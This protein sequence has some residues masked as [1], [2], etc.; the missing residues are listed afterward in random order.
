MKQKFLSWLVG[1]MS[2]AVVSCGGGGSTGPT[3]SANYGEIVAESQQQLLESFLVTIPNVGSIPYNYSKQNINQLIANFAGG[4]GLGNQLLNTG[5]GL[6]SADANNAN[7]IHTKNLYVESGTFMT[8]GLQPQVA[9]IIESYSAYAVQYKTPGQN[10]DID[11]NQIVRTASGLVIVPN[12]KT[13]NPIKGVVVY[14]HPTTPG[15]N[16]VPSCLGSPMPTP[17]APLTESLPAMSGNIPAYCNLTPIDNTG[18]GL[19]SML[20]TVFAARGFIVIAPDY[21]GQ[22]SDWNNVH[23]YTAYPTV[24]AQSAIYMFPALR[25]ILAKSGVAESSTVLPLFITG[26]S[27][28]GSYAVEMSRLI[29]NDYANYA[30]SYG[31]NLTMTSPQEGAYSLLDQSKFDTTEL[32]DGMFNCPTGVTCGQPNMGTESGYQSVNNWHIGGAPYEASATPVL[33]SYVL[34]ATNY[35]SFSNMA[36]AY[37][38]S[39][40]PKFWSQINMGNVVAT[41]YQLY[42]GIY[43]SIFT[44]AQIGTAIVTNTIGINGYNYPP[45]APKITFYN[46]GIGLESSLQVNLYGRNNSGARYAN[47]GILTNPQFLQIVADGSTY[48]WQT[49]SPINFIHMNYDSAVTVLNTHQAYNCMKYGHAFAGADYF[50]QGSAAPCSTAPSGNLIESTVIPNYQVNNSVQQMTPSNDG[51]TSKFWTTPANPNSAYGML[52]GSMAAATN[53]DPATLGVPFDHGDMFVLGSI[54]AMCSFINASELPPIN[55]GVCPSGY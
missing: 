12:M 38:M 24:N 14:F 13:G 41:L 4:Y 9:S 35:Y 31:L 36:S 49:R 20:S 8:V 39:M 34:T 6:K 19:F 22:G 46:G 48:N 54:I 7:I 11:P 37:S 5:M 21:V 18:A 25:D 47:S 17:I 2:L 53:K 52:L 50:P 42:S 10:A 45:F 32:Y 40:N 30:E 26:Y 27:E 29:Q 3:A 44:G 51:A 16:M 33:L 15:K 55:S 23:P 43:G 28:G 1:G